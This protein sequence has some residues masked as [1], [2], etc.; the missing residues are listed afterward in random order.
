V[1]T[2]LWTVHTY[3]QNPREF[4]EVLTPH[5]GQVFRNVPEK[6]ALYAGQPYLVD[7]FGGIWWHPGAGDDPSRKAS[8]GYGK[9]VESVEAYYERLE[10]LVD[11]LLS[12][13][14]IRGYCYTQLTDVEQEQNGLY[15]FDRQAKFDMERI[16]RI[17]SRIPEH[18]E[19]QAK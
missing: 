12:L 5:N 3:R 18:R 7:E 8:W 6:E 17:F 10:G 1:Q 9:R 11:V 2:D 15:T 14:H 4:R 19:N 16:M 13:P